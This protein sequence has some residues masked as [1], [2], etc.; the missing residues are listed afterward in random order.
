MLSARCNLLISSSF[1]MK[2]SLLI[3]FLFIAQNLQAQLTFTGEIRPRTEYRHGFKRLLSE[4]EEA[5]LFVE[6]RSRLNLGYR[7]DKLRIGLQ[8]QDVR[9][10]GE[11]AQINKS[12]GLFSVHQAWGE[13][14]F[15]H[16]LSLKVGRQELSYDD[17]RILGALDWAAQGRSHDAARLMWQDSTWQLHLGAA[18]NQNSNIPEPARLTGTFYDAPGSFDA[19]GGGLPNYKHMQM[20][21][22]EK[23]LGKLQVSALA[24]NTGWQMP[25]TTVNHLVT[26]GLNPAVHLSSQVKLDGSVYYQFGK[27]RL[28]QSTQAYLASAVLTYSGFKPLALTLGGDLLSGTDQ[29]EN[30]STTFDPLFGTNHK[31]YGQM[32][33][34]YVGNAHNQQGKSVGLVDVYLKTKAKLGKKS[35]LL[36]ELHQFST[37]V[38]LTD[39]TDQTQTLSSTLGT[40]IDLVYDLDYQSFINFKIGYSQML[41]TPGMEAIKGGDKD[42]LN[43]WAWVMITLKPDFLEK[44]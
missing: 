39:P 7:Q 16:K 40:E 41:A 32:D 9:V 36:T 37:Q 4:G 38:P 22:A 13:I 8:I 29:K 20:L 31:F 5:A 2:P 15:T 18:F 26:V 3:L 27:N 42:K 44:K 19:L 34:F 6:Q 14:L 17:Q 33:Y 24:L 28:D 25:D 30:T 23:K 35:A 43:Q 11:T 21:W 10:W 1:R 12:D